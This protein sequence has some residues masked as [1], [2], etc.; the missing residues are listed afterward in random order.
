[1]N[2]DTVDINVLTCPSSGAAQPSALLS[3][4]I[5]AL[6]HAPAI[7]GIED[8]ASA[9]LL[10]KSMHYS[11][12]LRGKRAR[13]L[14][15]LLIAEGWNAP[16]QSALDCAHAVEMVH[17][18][19]LIVDDLPSMDNASLRR[20]EPSNH[21]KFGEPTA[22]LAGISLLSEALRL[23]ASSKELSP[24]QRNDAVACLTSAIGP[25]GMA[26]GQ[27]RD[28]YPVASA[29]EDVEFT[30]ALKTGSLFAAAAELGC[31]AAGIDGP[32]KWMLSDYGMLLGKAF[33]EFDDLIDVAA[34]TQ[35]SGKDAQ[36][37]KDKPTVVSI[38][39]REVAAKRALRQVAMSLECLEASCI[40]SKELHRFT[41]EL[42]RAMRRTVGK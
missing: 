37:D 12:E 25:V 10:R 4:L 11:L 5:V 18:S 1:M 24:G 19:S 31:I 27:M 33:Q 6:A 21:E 30:H 3:D 8:G 15:V 20:G 34:P 26:A 17:T 13:G 29:V 39:G 42:T 16:W 35:A 9:E 38:V 40:Q 32:R 36:K 41:L 14:L 7:P 23:L 22:V 28:I 2:G